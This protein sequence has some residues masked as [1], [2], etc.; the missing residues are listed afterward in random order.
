MR[1]CDA[2]GSCAAGSS[3]VPTMS[4]R[5]RRGKGRASR[6]QPGRP[7]AFPGSEGP[8]SRSTC[9]AHEQASRDVERLLRAADDDDV[10][11]AGNHAARPA[12]RPR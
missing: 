11:R 8:R 9:L 5:P 2:A 12:S 4:A 10:I 6:R 7:A 3:G 1:G